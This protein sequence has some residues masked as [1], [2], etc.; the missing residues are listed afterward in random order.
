MTVV[1]IFCLSLMVAGLFG[2]NFYLLMRG[3]TSIENYENETAS[4]KAKKKVQH[5]Y[6]L[7]FIRNIKSVMGPSP[8]MWMWVL[9]SSMLPSPASNW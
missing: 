1:I 5:K 9:L 8:L 6:D 4:V 3:E 2:W 7:G